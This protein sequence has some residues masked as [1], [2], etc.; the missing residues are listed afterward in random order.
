M[1]ARP[2]LLLFDIDGTLIHK[3]GMG[4]AALRRAFLELYG[5]TDPLHGIRLD[6]KTDP[7]ICREVFER[8]ELNWS[9]AAWDQL[10]ERYVRCLEEEAVARPVGQLCPGVTQLLSILSGRRDCAL[11]LLTGNVRRGAE[12]KLRAFGIWD[13][14]TF[15][16]FGSDRELRPEL[17]AVALARAQERFGLQFQPSDAIVIGDTPADIETAKA[18]GCACV[19]VATGRFTVDE[20]RHLGPDFVLQDLGDLDRALEA[21]ALAPPPVASI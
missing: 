3:G 21:F 9:I 6:G 15:G 17:V 12:I 7:R 2:K 20:L 4:S 16:A 19:A 8:F 13:A 11:G 14:F 10:I 18:G 1:A 5:L